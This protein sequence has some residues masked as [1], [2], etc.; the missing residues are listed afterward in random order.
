MKISDWKNAV[1]ELG[2]LVC[3]QSANLHHPREGQGLSQRADD[4]LCVPLCREHHQGEDGWHGDRA[5]FRMQHK[6][7]QTEGD[8]LAATLRLLLPRL[9]LKAE[10]AQEPSGIDYDAM[11]QFLE[12]CDW[13]AM[14][15]A[16]AGD[17]LAARDRQTMAQLRALVEVCRSV[18][19]GAA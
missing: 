19:V 10:P 12:R 3:G 4:A 5:R 9:H 16:T 7:L 8:M 13:L 1:A 15:C 14:A 11:I 2:C 6:R 17:E 18:R